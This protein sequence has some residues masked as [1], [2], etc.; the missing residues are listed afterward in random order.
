[1]S[2]S[3][4]SAGRVFSERGDVARAEDDLAQLQNDLKELEEKLTE[5]IDEIKAEYPTDN[6]ELE[7]IPLR[8]K[9]ADLSIAKIVLVWTPWH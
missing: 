9:K 6:I 4:R 1:A 5:E 2:T 8:P 7:S 3:A